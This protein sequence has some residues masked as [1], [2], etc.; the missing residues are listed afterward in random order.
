MDFILK[1]FTDSKLGRFAQT[2]LR[3]V[4]LVHTCIDLSTPS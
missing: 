2:D 3:G 4:D 1:L